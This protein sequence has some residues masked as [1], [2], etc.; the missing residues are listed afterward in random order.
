VDKIDANL[1]SARGLGGRVSIP[2]GLYA[3]GFETPLLMLFDKEGYQGKTVGSKIY[4]SG[5]NRG[6]PTHNQT[7]SR[8]R[9]P[10]AVYLK[11]PLSALLELLF[12]FWKPP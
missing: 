4:T 10:T 12:A 9:L 3:G 7:P 1:A 5:W 6:E 8:F 11:A 2:A